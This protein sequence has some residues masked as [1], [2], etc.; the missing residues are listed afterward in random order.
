MVFFL[1]LWGTPRSFGEYSGHLENA[2]VLDKAFWPFGETEVLETIWVFFYF[3]FYF[4]LFFGSTFYI[5]TIKNT[6]PAH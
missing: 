5:A 6:C 2:W 3:Y 4:I 1:A